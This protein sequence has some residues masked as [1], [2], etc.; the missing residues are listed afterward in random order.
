M[1][2]LAAA[3]FVVFLLACARAPAALGERERCARSREFAPLRGARAAEPAPREVEGAD[4]ASILPVA[5]RPRRARRARLL[6]GRRAGHEYEI[7]ARARARLARCSR[8]RSAS[9]ARAGGCSRQ[10]NPAPLRDLPAML[11]HARAAGLRGEDL[12]LYEEELTGAY[13]VGRDLYVMREGVLRESAARAARAGDARGARGEPRAARARGAGAGRGAAAGSDRARR[14]GPRSPTSS[15]S[16]RSQ[17]AQGSLDFVPPSFAR[18]LVRAGWLDVL[19]RAARADRGAARGGAA[20]PSACSR[21]RASTRRARAWSSSRTRSATASGRSRHRER[22]GY[23]RLASPPAYYTNGAVTRLV[24]R[25]PPRQ[26]SAARRGALAARRS[27]GTDPSGSRP[28]TPRTAS[29]STRPTW[30]RRVPD[31]GR[32]RRVGGAARRA[33]AAHP[34]DGAERRRARARHRA[35][36]ARPRERRTRSRTPSRST[37]TPRARCPTPRTW[38]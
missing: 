26:R 19:Q 32:R 28:G 38:T 5:P 17:D 1:R 15:R 33:P 34:G 20:E 4:V 29:R 22:V 7:A 12:V 37:A 2:R 21:S 6:A 8:P 23:A 3:A 10:W 30:R 16:S 35:R 11:A 25:L 24:V 18:R 13:L 9:C 14:A 31:R 36:P 27:S